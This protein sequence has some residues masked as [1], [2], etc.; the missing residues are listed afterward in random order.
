MAAKLLKNF[1]QGQRI[2]E[3]ATAINR[4]AEAAVPMAKDLRVSAVRSMNANDA[5]NSLTSSD[6]SVTAF[7]TDKTRSASAA[8]F[9]KRYSG[10]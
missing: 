8:R 2:D 4:A 5:K 7:F 10:R 6:T 1:E 9:C 3:L